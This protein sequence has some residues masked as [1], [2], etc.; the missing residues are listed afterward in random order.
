MA[1]SAAGPGVGNS[2]YRPGMN[3]VETDLRPP[4]GTQ[5]TIGAEGQEAVVV[6]V[7][8][9][10][11]TYR[12]GDVDYVDGYAADEICA[13]SAGQ[14]LAPWPNR[15]R[16]GQYNHEGRSLQL[17][18]SEPDRGTAIHG[19]VNWLPWQL[20]DQ[21]PE[22]VTVQC[23]LSA[24]PGYPWSLLL[25]T[26]WQVGAGGLRASHEVTNL[27]AQPCP[28]GLS[29]HPYLRLPDVAVDDI[30]L[31]VPG[32]NRLLL[33]G[34]LLPIGAARVAGS[35]YDF[36]TGRRIGN[37]VLDTCFGDVAADP[38]GG[39]TVTLTGPDPTVAVSIWADPAFGW[40]QVYTGDTLG[41]ERRRRSVAVE[42]MTC[43]PDAFRSGR[44]VIRIGSGE[45]WRAEWGIRP[46]R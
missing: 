45:T 25:R 28:F 27:S 38:E 18:L 35:E 7:G 24:Q 41:G 15:I 12:S 40:W 17:S 32:R 2:R 37:L 6:E 10:L 39:S 16:D 22:S 1:G 11:R 14:I 36:T 5:W 4:S 3:F 33:D 21:R 43:P 19:L 29:V 23:E 8:G 31:R 20:V 9:G 30:T 13:G 46:G 34:R 26:R 44:D 42:P